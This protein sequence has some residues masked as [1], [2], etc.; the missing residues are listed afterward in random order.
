M[1]NQP[2]VHVRRYAYYEEFVIP[3][4]SQQPG[5]LPARASRRSDGLLPHVVRAAVAV[6]VTMLPLV[7]VRLAGARAK[8]A[9]G[10]A[11]RSVLPLPAGQRE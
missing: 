10:P 4:D 6:G 11:R 1:P 5:F 7:A 2:A 3:G 8:P 9:L